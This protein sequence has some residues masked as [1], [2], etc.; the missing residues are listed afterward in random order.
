MTPVG[1]TEFTC[2]LCTCHVLGEPGVVLCS[3]CGAEAFKNQDAV[4]PARREAW[5]RFM[6]AAISRPDYGISR[7]AIVEA[8]IALYDARI[9]E[10]EL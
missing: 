9:A 10:G 8:A 1:P 2:S 5:V 7:N 3:M 6:A 4:G